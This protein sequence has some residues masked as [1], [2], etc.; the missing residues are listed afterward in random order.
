MVNSQQAKYHRNEMALMLL[1][2]GMHTVIQEH[3][4]KVSLCC[5]GSA[6]DDLMSQSW[7]LYYGVQ[8]YTRTQLP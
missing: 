1:M 7:Q 5:R 8:K 3:P 6:E 4:K 2:Y